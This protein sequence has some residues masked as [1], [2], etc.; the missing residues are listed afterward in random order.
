MQYLLAYRL[1]TQKSKLKEII[2]NY[3]CIL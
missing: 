1:F 2:N 3:Y